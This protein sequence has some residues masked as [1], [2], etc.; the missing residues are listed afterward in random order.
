[1]DSFFYWGE[2]RCNT[3]GRHACK[4]TV[5]FVN[6]IYRLQCPLSNS[7]ATNMKIN[8]AVAKK[9][10]STADSSHWMGSMD[11]WKGHLEEGKAPKENQ[12]ESAQVPLLSFCP[13]FIKNISDHEEGLHQ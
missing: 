13:Y 4:L 6:T 12:K 5:C 3:K 1:M 2:L 7:R 11:T 10:K 8:H 9:K